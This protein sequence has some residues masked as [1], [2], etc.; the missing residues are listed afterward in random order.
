M[1]AHK[2]NIERLAQF[3]LKKEKKNNEVH[4]KSDSKQ[5]RGVCGKASAN[6]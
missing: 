2:K 1:G 4:F 3:L 5:A 6:K